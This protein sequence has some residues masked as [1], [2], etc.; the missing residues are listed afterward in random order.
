MSLHGARGIAAC[1][2]VLGHTANIATQYGSGFSLPS[3][4]FNASAAVVLFF[5]MSGIVLS[6]SALEASG[7]VSEL[8]KFYIRRAFRLMPLMIVVNI[9]SGVF[10]ASIHPQLPYQE[11]LTGPFRIDVFLV[12][13]VGATLKI[14]GPSWSIFIEIVASA[15]MPFLAVAAA[16]RFRW[17]WLVAISALAYVPVSTPYQLQI[18]LVP[19]FVGACIPFVVGTREVLRTTPVMASVVS[20]GFLLAFNF[21]RP[22]AHWVAPELN[23]NTSPLVVMAETVLIAPVMAVMFLTSWPRLLAAK[24]FQVLGDISFPLYLLHFNILTLVYNGVRIAGFDQGWVVFILSA[25]LT[26]LITLPLAW[27]ANAYIEVPG[28]AAGRKAAGFFGGRL[29]PRAL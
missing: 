17:L 12:G 22:V 23:V 19:F 13:F 3:G 18:F 2:V 26:F 1:I 27:L 20:I 11:P 4:L 25:F 21:V 15:L 5:V 14:N 16:S 28:I 7:G 10:V 9:A 29:R 8:T 24:V 6:P